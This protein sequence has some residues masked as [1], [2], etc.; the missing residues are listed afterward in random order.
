MADGRGLYRVPIDRAGA[1]VMT[2]CMSSPSAHDETIADA[3][4][5]SRCR[6]S[7]MADMASITRSRTTTMK[8]HTQPRLTLG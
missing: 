4:L 8:I 7:M 5:H 2:T 3:R 1:F 6:V